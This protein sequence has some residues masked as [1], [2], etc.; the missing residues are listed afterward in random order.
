MKKKLA[1]YLADYVEHELLKFDYR[2]TSM[3]N[4]T[5]ILE[6]GLEAFESTNGLTIEI[7]SEE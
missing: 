6:Q 5:G 2:L 1:K 3:Y 4:I 7:K